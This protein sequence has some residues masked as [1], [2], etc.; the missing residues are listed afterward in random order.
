MQWGG[1][2]TGLGLRRVDRQVRAHGRV[3][4]S[5]FKLY[6]GELNKG[7]EFPVFTNKGPETSSKYKKRNFERTGKKVEAGW[8][9]SLPHS[10]GSQN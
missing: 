5:L 3:T 1:Q 9:W 10:E 7:Q 4:K 6:I 2:G 8:K